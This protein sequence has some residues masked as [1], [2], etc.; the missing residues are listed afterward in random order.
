M[1]IKKVTLMS[2]TTMTIPMMFG[3]VY[4]CKSVV[5][6]VVNSSSCYCVVVTVDS[7]VVVVVSCVVF[8]RVALFFVITGITLKTVRL[9]T[10]R[11]HGQLP[12]MNAQ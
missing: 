4:P 10:G 12:Q 8:V 9:Q 7:V 3:L 1:T 11:A 2:M 5:S 6:I